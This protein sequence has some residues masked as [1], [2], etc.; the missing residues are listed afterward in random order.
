MRPTDLALLRTPGVPTVSPD[1]RIAVVAVSRLDLDADEYRGQL[2]AVPTDGSAPARPI[3]D[4]HR[5]SAPVY[6]PDG[7]WIAYLSAE[8]K[9][10]PQLH[11]LA[12]AGG[13][14]R[15]LTD[16]PLGAGAPVWSPDSRRLA[17]NARVPE[18]G[19]Y[20]TVEGVGPEAEPPRLITTLKYREDNVG[21]LIDRRSHLFVLDLPEDLED[22]TEPLPTPR[23][24]TSGDADCTGVAW[25]PDGG[26]LAF[27]SAQHERAER[28]LVHDVYVIGVDGTGLRR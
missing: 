13:A 14:P 28:D 10:K 1:G 19:R 6:S 3:T 27:V 7:R 16:H 18:P 25:S 26:S 5:D 9:G 21:F 17:Y 11:V 8:A 2:W 4:G 24:V 22:N 12:T 20:G 15:K 23:Q